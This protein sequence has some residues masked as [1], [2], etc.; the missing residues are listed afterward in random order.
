MLQTLDAWTLTLSE[1]EHL[2][3]ACSTDLAMACGNVDKIRFFILG[4]FPTQKRAADFLIE[5]RSASLRIG[6]S[7]T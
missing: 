1:T 7:S 6:K 5:S 2:I 3:H 4:A